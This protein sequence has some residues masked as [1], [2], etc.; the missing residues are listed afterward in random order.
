MQ[1]AFVV[2]EGMPVEIKFQSDYLN[3]II[4]KDHD[5][6]F[7]MYKESVAFNLRPPDVYKIRVASIELMREEDVF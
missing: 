2:Y 1:E 5:D 6:W 3:F 4:G 7:V